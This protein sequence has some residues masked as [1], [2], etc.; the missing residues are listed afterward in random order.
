MMMAGRCGCPCWVEQLGAGL[1]AAAVNA[2]F[3][4]KL[5]QMDILTIRAWGDVF[6]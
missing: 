5:D 1:A 4:W 6:P 2:V 3:F